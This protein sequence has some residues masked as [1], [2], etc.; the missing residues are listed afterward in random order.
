L[1]TPADYVELRALEI[2]K[3][4]AEIT[5]TGRGKIQPKQIERSW[6]SDQAPLADESVETAERTA[7]IVPMT[8]QWL[9]LFA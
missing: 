6:P 4:E 8:G 3:Q 7:V 1:T 5:S 2:A 9:D